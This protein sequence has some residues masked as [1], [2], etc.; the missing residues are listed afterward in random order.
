MKRL[1]FCFVAITFISIP[2]VG[3]TKNWKN[4]KMT[5]SDVKQMGA[6]Y[7]ML[8][9]DQAIAKFVNDLEYLPKLFP[10]LMKGNETAITVFPPQSIDLSL[11]KASQQSVGAKLK[12]KV[13]LH[14]YFTSLRDDTV[15][16]DLSI[17]QR[18]ID[19][20][21]NIK[22]INIGSAYVDDNVISGFQT[23][24]RNTY[25]LAVSSLLD[26]I[27]VSVNIDIVKQIDTLN[28]TS[29]HSMFV[30]NQDILNVTTETS[31]NIIFE[32]PTQLFDNLIDYKAYDEKGN[33]IKL[34]SMFISSPVVT[35]NYTNTMALLDEFVNLRDSILLDFT[36]YDT[37]VSF[38]RALDNLLANFQL[39]EVEDKYVCKLYYQ[40]PVHQISFYL[41]KQIEHEKINLT[42]P[43]RRD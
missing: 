38:N 9:V 26:S 7:K 4:H 15:A 6:E 11:L 25:T 41:I 31:N 28:W 3:Q 27:N 14:Q 33:L 8:S 24:D 35:F 19:K 37:E 29:T 30:I 43:F 18:E 1:I 39:K 13:K 22:E 5:S 34:D 42:I 17:S 40:K 16:V 12:K 21:L 20:L 36:A 23:K 32:C 2:I 10:L